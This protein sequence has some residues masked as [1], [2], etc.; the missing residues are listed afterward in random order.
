M[1][2]MVDPTDI[3]GLKLCNNCNQQNKMQLNYI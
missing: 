3:I 1:P 2:V